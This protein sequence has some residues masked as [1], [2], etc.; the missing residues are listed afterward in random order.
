MEKLHTRRPEADIGISLPP[1]IF[2]RNKLPKRIAI[3]ELDSN[4]YIIY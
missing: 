2:S 4:V 3:T 1:I